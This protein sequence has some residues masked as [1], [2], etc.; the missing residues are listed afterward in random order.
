MPFQ[1][2][3]GFPVRVLAIMVLATG[4]V[5]VMEVAV[6][7]HDL[8]PFQVRFEELD[9][10]SEKWLKIFVL[11]QTQPCMLW[12]RSHVLTIWNFLGDILHI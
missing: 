6:V 2:L 10:F 4:V 3:E 11:A 5:A 8:N 7:I 9:I 12:G 1:K